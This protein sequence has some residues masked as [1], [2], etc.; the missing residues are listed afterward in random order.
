MLLVHSITIRTRIR[1]YINKIAQ[2]ADSNSSSSCLHSII[3]TVQC[4]TVLCT[5]TCI[6]FAVGICPQRTMYCTDLYLRRSFE[7]KLRK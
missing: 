2:V 7:Y 5:S 6:C 3:A 1:I 4:S